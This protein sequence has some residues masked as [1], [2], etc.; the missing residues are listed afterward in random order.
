MKRAETM[1]NAPVLQLS[2]ANA[3]LIESLKTT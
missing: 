2:S 1:N 3:E